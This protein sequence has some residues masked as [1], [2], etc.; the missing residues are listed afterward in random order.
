MKAKTYLIY[1]SYPW[2][3]FG[4]RWPSGWPMPSPLTVLLVGGFIVGFLASSILV[5]FL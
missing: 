2:L 5:R 4:I 3:K 1:F